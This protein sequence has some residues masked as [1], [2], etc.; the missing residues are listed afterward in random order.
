MSL[1]D[2]AA[3]LFL[4]GAVTL[5]I[6]GG[7]AHLWWIIAVSA[8]SHLGLARTYATLDD[9]DAAEAALH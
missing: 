3:T 9:L 7:L 8:L 1:C 2:R 4:D 5:G 6:P